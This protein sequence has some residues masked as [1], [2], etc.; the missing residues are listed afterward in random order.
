[1]ENLL[2]KIPDLLKEFHNETD[3]MIGSTSPNSSIEFEFDI[4]KGYTS[5]QCTVF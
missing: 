2:L 3:D 5:S 1:M 4:Q